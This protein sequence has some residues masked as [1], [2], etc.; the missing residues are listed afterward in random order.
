VWRDELRSDVIGMHDGE[1]IGTE[2]EKHT[3]TA[4]NAQNGRGKAR[5]PSTKIARGMCSPAD[6]EK[7]HIPGNT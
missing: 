3:D 5:G 7:T 4:D 6:G 2:P 1:Q